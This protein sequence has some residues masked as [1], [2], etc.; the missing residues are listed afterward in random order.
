MDFSSWLAARPRVAREEGVGRALSLSAQDVAR[1]LG[2]FALTYDP[3]ETPVF[4]REWDTL[5]LLDAC[6]V[7]ALAAVAADYGF[8][9]EDI[10]SVRS[11]ASASKGW[12]RA[13]FTDT[14]AAETRQTTYVTANPF[15]ESEVDSDVFADVDEV[16]TYGW[17]G[18]AGTVPAR[19]VTSRAVAAGRAGGHKRLLVHYM[20]P[21]FPSVPDPL[22]SGIDIKTFGEGWDSIWGRLEA[23]ELPLERAWESYLANLRYVLDDVELLLK[24]LDAETVV[25]SADHGNAFGEWNVYGHPPGSPIGAV[26]RVPWVETTATDTGEYEPSL[27]RPDGDGTTDDAVEDRLRN[28]GY[29]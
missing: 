19:H 23:G 12:M 6:R 27:E 26:R 15:S 24:N 9:P 22:G 16:W 13:N 17:D 5:V 28:L 3:R 7:D 21:H 11:T 8:L 4:E 10:P 29:V 18:D 14:Y 1:Q 20:Q 25:I 2:R